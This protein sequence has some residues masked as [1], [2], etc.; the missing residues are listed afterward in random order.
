MSSPRTFIIAE[1]GV[2]HNG[3]LK[4]AIRM[5]GIA[6]E[7]GAD[8]VKFQSFITEHEVTRDAP[9][10]DY[11]KK[12]AGAAGGQFAMLKALE[13]SAADHRAL[14]RA[15][16]NAGIEFM[17][18]AFDHVSAAFLNKLGGLRRHKI[19]SGE[20]TNAPLLLQLARSRKPILLSTGMATLAEV[21]TALGVIA[22]GYVSGE[23]AK[24]S[25]K[26]FAAAFRSRDGQM[27]LK[28]NVAVLQCTSEYPAAF[29]RINLRAMATL[30]DTFGLKVGLSDHS[31]G[32]A[33]AVAAVARGATVIEKHFTLDRRLPGPDHKASLEPDELATLVSSIRAVE[34][35]FGRPDKK[36]TVGERNVRAVARKSLVALQTI[37]AGERFTAA[38]LGVKR[39]GGGLQPML[40]WRLLG[41]KATRRYRRD[42]QISEV[43]P[44]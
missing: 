30:A 25:P 41:R 15:C 39:P 40:Y 32:V 5:V 36:P 24:P 13:L 4:R 17:S 11:Q 10:A 37:R 14:V 2:N 19:A 12:N 8:A 27:A 34:A 16:R 3:S 18:T 9:K 43:M 23:N 33:V 22:F 20:I 44:A 38:N 21:E 31:P 26:A 28:K 7:A 1:V 29:D 42:E 6:A 35:A